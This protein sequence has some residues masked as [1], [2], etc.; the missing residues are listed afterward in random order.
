VWI[1]R[2]L[3]DAIRREVEH[4][5]A[6]HYEPLGLRVRVG[7]AELVRDGIEIRQLTITD[8]KLTGD[9]ARLAD[10][11]ELHV[12]CD[13]DADRLMHGQFIVREIQIS[14][15]TLRAIRAADG[16]WPLSRLWP[17]PKLSKLPRPPL[18]KVD[19]E[20]GAIEISTP[21]ANA[22]RRF[23]LQDL[24]LSLV[25]DGPLPVGAPAVQPNRLYTVKGQIAGDVVRRARIAGWIDP[26]S[27]S[28]SVDGGLD[29]LELSDDVAALAAARWPDAAPTGDVRGQIDLDFTLR[30]VNRTQQPAPL[31]VTL[32]GQL[33]GGHIA[34]RRLP[35]PITDIN[36]RF[37]WDASGFAVERA[38]A[39][40]GAASITA[41]LQAEKL[42]L[43]SPVEIFAEARH[44]VA[45]QRWADALPESARGVWEKFLPDGEADARLH[46]KFDGRRWTPYAVVEFHD[47]SFAYHK[48]PYRVRQAA[49]NLQLAGNELTTNVVAYVGRQPVR[50]T[51][52]TYNPGP[53][54]T[55][56]LEVV[57]DRIDLHDELI[58]ALPEKPARVVQSLAARGYGSVYARFERTD[59]DSPVV[60]HRMALGVVNGAVKYE[61]FP[62]VIEN[63]RG[64]LRAIDNHWTWDDLQ[65]G[66][67]TSHGEWIP[68]AVGQGVLK[69]HLDAR[70]V[71]LD[72]PLRAALPA[73][74]RQ[75]WYDLHPRGVIDDLGVDVQWA[76]A[77]RKLDLSIVADKA[78]RQ[79]SVEEPRDSAAI[80][81][82]HVVAPT[83]SI[84]MEPVWFPIRLDQVHGQGRYHNGRVTLNHVQATHDRATLA[85]SGQCDCTPHGGFRL[86]FENIMLDR[87]NVDRQLVDA[88]PGKLRTVL[89]RLALS[90][91]VNVRGAFGLARAARDQPVA[92]DWDLSMILQRNAIDCGVKLD[93]LHGAVHLVGQQAADGVMACL[94]ELD[95]DAATFH[96]VQFANVRGPLEVTDKQLLFGSRARRLRANDQASALT[97]KV[98]GGRATAEAVV[99]LAAKPTFWLQAQL[100]DAD[101]RE[102]AMEMI[103]GRQEVSGK[104]YA[105]TQLWGGEELHS[106]RGEGKV[107]LRDANVYQLPVMVAMLKVLSIRT[108]DST[109]FTSG[110]MDYRVEGNHIYLN[111]IDVKGDAISLLGKGEATFDRQVK[112][113]FYTVVGRDE[114]KLPIIR[115]LLGEASRQMLQIRVDGTLDSPNI[116]QEA[117]PGA[118]QFLQQVQE[119]LARGAEGSDAAGSAREVLRRSGNLLR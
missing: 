103:P 10:I 5:L 86:Q 81:P 4:R 66:E 60:H 33:T 62:L 58:A 52:K 47:A 57:A 70:N 22:Y 80:L 92:T 13:L 9:A 105:S 16:A 113:N 38:T 49:G 36:A 1:W 50:I 108:P 56:W 53:R 101:V 104:I 48:F 91:P 40:F 75:L 114:L 30:R 42:D 84:S 31:E 71:A 117:F 102:Y 88:A 55:G 73:A 87:L 25:T 110:D 2:D 111:R 44:V 32:R 34:D 14:H 8:P 15:P 67:I 39:Q 68:G 17:L 99:N 72:E 21:V 46:L 3:D 45:D 93:N 65:S 107:R 109:G 79:A 69:M 78:A 85:A 96:G 29:G 118:K 26:D 27:K 35:N 37:R 95:L 54:F 76:S 106:L 19:I 41:S 82:A 77:N 116:K 112:L 115:P 12:I 24:Q 7:S 63:I 89:A 64:T 100:A 61:K 11:D 98:Y 20:G 6:E 119:D 23:R 59:P 83:E 28:W 18:P 51:A 74:S 94:G 90:E 43:H 97:A